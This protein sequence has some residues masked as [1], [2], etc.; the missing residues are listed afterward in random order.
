MP[1]LLPHRHLDDPARYLHINLL[2]TKMGRQRDCQ[3]KH[4]VLFGYYVIREQWTG[5]NFVLLENLTASSFRILCH[6]DM[7][8][9]RCVKA[10]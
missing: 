8:G 1:M 4:V 9:Q 2:H 6:L 7:L 3:Y 5:G 10:V